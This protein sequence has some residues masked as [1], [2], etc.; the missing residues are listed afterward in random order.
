MSFASEMVMPLIIH[1]VKFY[2]TLTD[3]NPLQPLPEQEFLKSINTVNVLSPSF[4]PAILDIEFFCGLENLYNKHLA[5][6]CQFFATTT[7]SLNNTFDF[8]ATP[9]MNDEEDED[10]PSTSTKPQD[11]V[12]L[13]WNKHFTEGYMP[14]VISFLQT[15]V[16]TK[17]TH[18]NEDRDIQALNHLVAKVQHRLEIQ[19]YIPG[20]SWHPKQLYLPL[21]TPSFFN[22]FLT[23]LNDVQPAVVALLMFLDPMCW[24]PI[25]HARKDNSVSV[26]KVLEL[27]IEKNIQ[28]S[29][30]THVLNK[31][32]SLLIKSRHT[33]L[34]IFKQ[35]LA[36][37]SY[38]TFPKTNYTTK[39]MSQHTKIAPTPPLKE[40]EIG[41]LNSEQKACM[42]LNTFM[43]HLQ[44]LKVQNGRNVFNNEDFSDYQATNPGHKNI[45]ITCM[46]LSSPQDWTDFQKKFFSTTA[47]K[48]SARLLEAFSLCS[49][50]WT[51]MQQSPQIKHL[52]SQIQHT[53]TKSLAS[54]GV[55]WPTAANWEF[56]LDEEVNLADNEHLA[57]LAPL[58][59][60]VAAS[61]GGRAMK[62][63]IS[64]INRAFTDILDVA[65]TL[66]D[67]EIQISEDIMCTLQQLLPQVGY[68]A[69]CK[70]KKYISKKELKNVDHLRADQI[71]E[72]LIGH[73]KLI[74]TPP[75]L[76]SQLDD[77]DDDNDENS[78]PLPDIQDKGKEKA[79]ATE[80]DMTIPSDFDDSLMLSE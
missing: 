34:P 70:H 77:N 68:A 50:F 56:S 37:K 12:T 7:S 24:F 40:H 14:A 4:N 13:D 61:V 55:F 42:H 75:I 39:H 31:I 44:H 51:I 57:Y 6:F 15:W 67:D 74:E 38:P 25:N 33:T 48:N 5:P 62:S 73:A 11:M 59:Q 3:P 80:E 43:L 27:W 18:F 32:L 41:S 49:F 21:L 16:K 72:A 35:K 69:L 54:N 20:I 60:D 64:K 36:S 1:M 29:K 45:T 52:F 26:F 9:N 8:N 19:T 46:M 71:K 28:V 47:A 2:L 78:E 17:K 10:T 79:F 22:Y 65:A 30:Q 53:I 63:M 66:N 76:I 23:S 58:Q